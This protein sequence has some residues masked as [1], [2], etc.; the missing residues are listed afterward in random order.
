MG[1]KVCQSTLN[2]HEIRTKHIRPKKVGSTFKLSK[3]KVFKNLIRLKQNKP[4]NDSK[5]AQ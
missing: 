2:M 1:G 3:K 5:T 4:I